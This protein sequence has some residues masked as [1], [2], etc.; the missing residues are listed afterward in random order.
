MRTAE[1]S[2]QTLIFKMVVFECVFAGF[3]FFDLN[4][5]VA[6]VKRSQALNAIKAPI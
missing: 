5:V 4:L 2:F 1:I 3:V 6:C